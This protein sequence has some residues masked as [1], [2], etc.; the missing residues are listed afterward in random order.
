M[1]RVVLV[2]KPEATR[3][4]SSVGTVTLPYESRHRRRVRLSD[5]A[6]NPFLLDLPRATA[7]ASGDLLVLESGDTLEVL[8][9]LER[10]VDIA[11]HDPAHLARIA[12]HIGNR[13][14]PLQ[15]LS[16]STLRIQHDHVLVEMIHGLGGGTTTHEAVFD[17]ERGAYGGHG[18]PH[19]HG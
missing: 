15:V 19:G 9:A 7:L 18:Q 1:R 8:A 2:A 6:G 10:V 16:A 3:G 11:C 12:W 13:H 5:D 4:R 14:V 17:P